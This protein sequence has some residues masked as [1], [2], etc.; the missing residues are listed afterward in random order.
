[1]RPE[2]IGP[3]TSTPLSALTPLDKSGFREGSG[4]ITVAGMSESSPAAVRVKLSSVLVYDISGKGFTRF[5]GMPGFEAVPLI[6]GES[7]QGRFFVF[8]QQPS[9]DRLVPPNPE[10]PLPPGPVLKSAPEAVDRVYWYALG[11]AP[12]SGERRK[13]EAA[14]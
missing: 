10:T 3:E 1:I 2:L 12:T 13:A 7:V 11:R 6:Q 4:P 5:R 9:M 14:L 8:D